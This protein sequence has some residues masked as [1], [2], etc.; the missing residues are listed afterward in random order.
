MKKGLILRNAKVVTTT[1]VIEQDVLI[2]D[3]TIA[4][5]GKKLK[6]E[7]DSNSIDIS[8][9]YLLPGFRDQHT[10]H[11]YGQ[12]G[13]DH[14]T[15]EQIAAKA[16]KV[17]KAKAKEGV[18]DLSLATFGGSI[19]QIE[20]YLKGLKKYGDSEK[21]GK[22]GAKLHGGHIEGTFINTECRG[23]QL[24]E[25][26]F[27]PDEFTSDE[28]EKQARGKSPLGFCKEIIDIF[29]DTGACT[30]INIVPDYGEPSL[31]IIEHAAKKGVLVGMGHTKCHANDIRAALDRGMSFFV[32]FTNGP[33]GHNTKPFENGGAYEGGVSLPIVKEWI[34]D[35][36]HI[37]Y[38]IVLDV[39]K[40]S[41]EVHG[42][43]L[44]N[45][46]IVTDQLFPMPEEV[47]KGDFQMGTTLARS[48]YDKG[49]IE[50][51]GYLKD[52]KVIPPPAN[53]LCSSLGTMDKCFSNYISIRTRDM[54][55]VH[56]FHKAVP[57][58][59]AIIEAARLC[60]TSQARLMNVGDSGII[61]TGKRANLVV[62][63]ISG[64]DGNYTLTVERVFVDGLEVYK[65]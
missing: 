47:P 14:E 18:T 64:S 31:V 1:S 13:A 20:S 59:K 3:G 21:N 15:V 38:R 17:A 57:L 6:P 45:F 4:A 27:R 41:M 9:K 5:I 52:G 61:E 2:L 51:T 11:M 35:G 7:N 8:G 28:A 50:V 24:I 54:K 62:G 25:Y 12:V 53:T 37:D 30:L 42:Q 49:F 36:F 29:C 34:L 58:D 44:D 43:S 16:G 33:T 19:H 55:G 46:L 23:A 65:S 60:A 56:S 26:V 63:D 48:N 32:H 40:G 39:M 10:H 22:E